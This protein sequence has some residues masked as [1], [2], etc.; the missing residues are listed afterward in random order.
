MC[1]PVA[2]QVICQRKNKTFLRYKVLIYIQSKAND[3]QYVITNIKTHP[4]PFTHEGKKDIFNLA[5]SFSRQWDI[6]T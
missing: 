4:L 5:E 2:F 1:V 6:K 3:S